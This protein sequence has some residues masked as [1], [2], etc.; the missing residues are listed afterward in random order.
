MTVRAFLRSLSR[1]QSIKYPDIL[2]AVVYKWNNLTKFP[3][4]QARRN[5]ITWLMH[6]SSFSS[7]V[8]DARAAVRS[9]VSYT[10]EFFKSFIIFSNKLKSLKVPN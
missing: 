2:G 6:S 10:K 3:S 8:R 1:N 5:L 4:A 7:A 9:V